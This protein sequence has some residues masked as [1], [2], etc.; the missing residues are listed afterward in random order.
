MVNIANISCIDESI[1]EILI[2][3]IDFKDSIFGTELNTFIRKFSLKI[4]SL[5][6][7]PIPD[8]K[9]GFGEIKSG[10]VREKS[11]IN[12]NEIIINNIESIL[13]ILLREDQKNKILN[14]IFL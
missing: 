3:S 11:F 5:D 12:S 9:D 10:A 8:Y 7:K 2:K 13:K 6:K 4:S 1:I 14:K